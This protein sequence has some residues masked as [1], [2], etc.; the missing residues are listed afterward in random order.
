[1]PDQESAETTGVGQWFRKRSVDAS[2]GIRR[3]RTAPFQNMFVHPPAR[4]HQ[5]F[6]RRDENK[7][8][9]FYSSR[10]F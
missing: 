9:I 6:G 8:V 10:C 4:D 3:P 5:N 1:M 2:E 7:F